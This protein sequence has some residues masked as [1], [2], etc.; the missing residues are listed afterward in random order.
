MLDA[1]LDE[2]LPLEVNVHYNTEGQLKVGKM[3]ATAFL[4][5]FGRSRTTGKQ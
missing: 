2:W 5:E 4:A 1:N 3:F